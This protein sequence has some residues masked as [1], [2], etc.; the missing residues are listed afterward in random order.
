LGI[1][2]SNAMTQQLSRALLPSCG[3][4]WLAEV[5]LHYIMYHFHCV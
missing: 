3:Y 4:G 1:N 2:L 5:G